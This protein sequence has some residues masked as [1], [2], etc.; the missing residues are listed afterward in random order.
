MMGGR[1]SPSVSATEFALGTKRN[2]NNGMMYVVAVTKAGIHRWV[3]AMPPTRGGPHKSI[4]KD[5]D[6]LA[7]WRDRWQ[8]VTGRSQD[9]DDIPSMS[10][11]DV[12]DRLVYYRSSEAHEQMMEYFDAWF[13]W[14]GY[15]AK[16]GFLTDRVMLGRTERRKC[17]DH[18]VCGRGW[19]LF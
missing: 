14:K 15:Y 5:R 13:D 11:K 18:L 9:L 2:G 1:P 16:H 7:S 8:V 10:K 19:R 6:E 17:P 3:P 4:N 12:A